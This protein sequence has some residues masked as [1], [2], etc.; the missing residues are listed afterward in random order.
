MDGAGK[1]TQISLLRDYFSSNKKN[2]TV[3]WARGG[4]TPGFE[5]LKSFL[6]FV[7]GRK[8]PKGGRSDQRTK[9][10]SKPFV[11]KLW[12]NIAIIDLIFIYTYL[13]I[14]S[15]F[16]FYIICDRYVEDTKLDFLIN[17]PT[18]KFQDYTSWKLLQFIKP[19]PDF[20]FLLMVSPSLSISRGL[21][22]NEPFPDDEITL[23]KRYN[24]YSDPTIFSPNQYKILDCSVS[25]D[26]VFN[27]IL[28]L[29]SSKLIIR[30]S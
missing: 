12:L 18:S 15:L 17:F 25:K 13:R 1:S 19:K 24:L 9:T 27:T 20:S 3:Y 7:L 8:L 4:Y 26:D 10:I 30:S 2:S 16:G 14:K 28:K 21:E 6:R 22:K 11:S 5:Y 29:V 23:K